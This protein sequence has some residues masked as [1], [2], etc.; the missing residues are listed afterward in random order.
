MHVPHP[1]AT[2]F[3]ANNYQAGLLA[4]HYLGRWAKSRW[5]GQVDEVVLVDAARAG[6]LVHGR[7]AGVVAGLRETLRDAMAS[8][9]VVTIDGDGQ[10]KL[11]LERVRRH[12][13]RSRAKRCWSAR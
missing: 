11:S 4:G 12:L 2:Y 6:P 3:G 1:G 13:R 10:F 9:P 8:C 7:M 5:N